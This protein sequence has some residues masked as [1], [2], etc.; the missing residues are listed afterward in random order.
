MWIKFSQSGALDTSGDLAGKGK[1]IGNG[2][3][4]LLPDGMRFIQHGQQRPLSGKVK[5]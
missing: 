4:S 1:E 5:C 3:I 2:H